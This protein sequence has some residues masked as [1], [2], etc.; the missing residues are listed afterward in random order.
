MAVWLAHDTYSDGSEDRPGENLISATSLLRS[1]RQI[2]LGARL[3]PGDNP[4]DVS[5]LIASRFGNAVHDS[6]EFAW[7]NGYRDAM[8]KLGYP[9]RMIEKIII[10][11]EDHELEDGMIPVYLE[12]RAF[13]KIKVD[14]REFTISG[15]FDKIING[16]LNDIKTTSVYA[17]INGTKDEDYR[18]QMSLYRWINPEKVTSE[19]FRIQHIFTDWQRFQTNINKDYPRHRVQEYTGELLPLAQTETWIRDK[20]REILVNQ[21]LPEPEIK[22]CSDQEL[23]MSDSVWKYYSDPERAKSGGRSTRN[24]TDYPSAATHQSRAGKGVIIEVPG[25]PRACSFCPVFTICSQ[26]DQYEHE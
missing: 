18:L 19:L 13:R 17:A 6:V 24:F 12:Q 7:K 5:D 10:N 25:K 4:I 16:E 15:K 1:T 23:W 26:K 9:K 3:E 21:E 20:I 14:G 11:P 2:V 22:P 8:T